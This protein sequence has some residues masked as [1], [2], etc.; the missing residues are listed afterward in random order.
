MTR[1]SLQQWQQAK[2]IFTEALQLS[3]SAQKE[4]LDRACGED[5][6]LRNEVESLLNSYQHAASFMEVP[7]VESA[8]ES[9]L[10]EASQL[11]PGQ[12]IKHYEIVEQI[13]E[14]GM[15]EVY[16]ARDTILGRRV[17]L[18]FLPGY[19][20]SD[21]D[22]LRRFQQEAR[23]A[24]TL[25]HPNVCVIH[26]VGET[27]DGHPFI[28]ME[29]IE[30][31]TLR[32]RMGSGSIAVNEALEISVQVAEALSAAHEAGIVHRDIKP[33]NIMI[34]K[35]GYVKV[36]DFGLAKL[37]EHRKPAG[38]TMS[39]LLMQSSPGAVM[40]TA[41]YMSPEQARG[42]DVDA[43]TDVWS[44]GVV[45]YEMIAG[46]PPFV[47]E[48]PTDVVV[49]IVDREPAAI[50]EH[51]GDVP[52]ELERIVR[53]ALRKDQT[54]RYQFVKEMAIDLRAL[55][56]DLEIDRSNAP[57]S[58]EIG[59]RQAGVRKTRA[60]FAATNR[61]RSLG[62]G[63][64]KSLSFIA[65]AIA[66]L[67]VISI[68]LFGLY[69]WKT[70]KSPAVVGRFQRINVTKLTTNGSAIYAA[71]SP[72]GKYVSYIKSEGGKESLW[73]RQISTTAN[74]E[75]ISAKDGHYS[76]LMFAPD[77]NFIY[78]AY[79]TP[80]DEVW[81]IYKVPTL[82][83]GATPLRVNP[84]EGPASISRDGKR[85]AFVRFD[86]TK[87]ADFLKVANVDGSNEQI[88]AAR[89]WP[90]RLSYDISATPAWT[91]NDQTLTLAM[92]NNDTAGFYFNLY[93]IDLNS[94]A[95][96]TISLA[97]LRFEQPSRITLLPDG[98]GIVT[99]GKVQ[100]ASFAQ[101][102][103]LGRD[104]SARSI[105]NDLSDYRDAGVTDDAAALVTIQNQTLA[106]LFVV[107]NNDVRNQK[108]ITFGLG[109]Y[110]DLNWAPDNKIVYASDASGSADIF[111]INADGTGTRQLTSGM[112][113]NYAPSVSPD[114]RYIVFH[115]NRSG[116]FQIWRMDRD[117]GNPVQLTNSTPECNWPTFSPDSK[118]VFFQH[119]EPGN[120]VSLWKVSVDGGTPS[121]VSPPGTALRPVV[122]PDGKW[123]GFWQNDGDANSKW[124]L[125][126]M[127]L[128]T[129]KIVNR[130]DVSPTVH[131]QWD[132]QLR[133]TPDSH[134]LAY[135][136]TRAGV[137]N[138]WVQLI[139]GSPAKQLTSFNETDIFAY[140][141]SRTG[142]LVISRGVITGD[143]VLIADAGK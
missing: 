110:F 103:L 19:L 9:L 36:L 89:S 39:T 66:V 30:G 112:K 14:G 125:A 107:Q 117:G 135:V 46:E 25:S 58:R 37:T 139:D 130:F 38:M 132:T 1:V 55:Q 115:S 49:A 88:V 48:T 26:E 124:R 35:D 24:S 84:E 128:E 127:S 43:R 28:T 60:A 18:K 73:L 34:R 47:G 99:S 11:K 42:V 91:N 133:W 114:N 6:A 22:R 106:N 87:R 51:L 113:R 85:M 52:D 5:A 77:G 116:T 21:P 137:Q 40:G 50:A 69:K 7:V 15:G 129:E 126:V 16:L 118:S 134:G 75:I 72:D 97:P 68:T 17:A 65:I 70:A 142:S 59:S 90:E 2:E 96:K 102:W 54:L 81:Q 57:R 56:K 13:G 8:A 61:I 131:V 109:R 41:A 29:Y 62:M 138:L 86:R 10:N 100:G 111:E 71:I 93:E 33:E 105:T 83:V 94:R 12:R 140:D 104:G 143:V 76:G 101:V 122:S 53:K 31:T 136:D 27:D 119:F 95:E 92:I 80:T 3:G 79:A 123:L 121:R 108:Q 120:S 74:V 64:S 4:F 78:Y 45:I 141:W 32:E 82:G 44:L 67:A 98:N 63:R 20:R 23:A